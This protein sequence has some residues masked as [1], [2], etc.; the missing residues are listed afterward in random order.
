[1]VDKRHVTISFKLETEKEKLNGRILWAIEKYG[2]DMV[3][4]NLLG[5]KK[6]VKIVYNGALV[7]K[8]SDGV[9]EY[10]EDI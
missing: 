1:M 9:V 7:E 10:C 3:V 6:W 5:Q 8:G 4:G 2:I